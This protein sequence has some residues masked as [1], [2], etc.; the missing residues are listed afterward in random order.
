MT[1]L[2]AI[3]TPGEFVASCDRDRHVKVGPAKPANSP[4]GGGKRAIPDRS[5]VDRHMLV[6]PGQ[7]SNFNSALHE[8]WETS[9]SIR[10]VDGHTI[11]SFDPYFQVLFPSRFHDPL[12]PDAV[13]R[14]IDICYETTPTGE[15]ARGDECEASTGNGAIAGIRY[16]DP[17]SQFNGVLRFVDINGN[18][19]R[20]EAG[21]EIWYSD[22]FG[23]NARSEPFP[24]S[25]RQY[26][27]KVDNGGREGH[28]PVIGRKRDHG[29]P[30]VRAPN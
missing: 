18:R 21:P 20:N 1:L 28:G 27:A 26:I 12:L 2:S 3:G 17:R 8:S 25:I 14:P 5:C 11:A 30:G 7:S 22:P 23:R 19:I 10:T 9:N 24:G 16:D 6:P 15:C 13:G 29:G 4:T